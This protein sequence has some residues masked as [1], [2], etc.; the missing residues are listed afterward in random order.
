MAISRLW[1][2]RFVHRYLHGERRARGRSM[3]VGMMTFSIVGG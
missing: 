3:I 1:A 2:V